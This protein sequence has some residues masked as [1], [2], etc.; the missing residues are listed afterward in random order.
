MYIGMYYLPLSSLYELAEA[1]V[2][3]DSMLGAAVSCRV[4]LKQKSTQ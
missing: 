2:L 4:Y 3:K 1:K